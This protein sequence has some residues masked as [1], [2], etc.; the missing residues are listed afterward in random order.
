MDKHL[1]ASRAH[2]Q[3]AVR[4][5]DMSVALTMAYENVPLD[6]EMRRQVME[7][8]LGRWRGNRGEEWQPTP[9]DIDQLM[10]S[11][12]VWL[13]ERV[14]VNWLKG[15]DDAT[16]DQLPPAAWPSAYPGAYPGGGQRSLPSG[17]GGAMPPPLI[18]P[19]P[20]AASSGPYPPGSVSAGMVPAGW[21]PPGWSA[22]SWTPP[23]WVALGPRREAEGASGAEERG[24]AGS[25]GGEPEKGA[26]PADQ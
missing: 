7:D 4:W 6:R 12:T 5:L 19:V 24:E 15:T 10:E 16:P 22:P 8:I 2:L 13:S 17:V 11:T 18:R 9:S 25:D 20:P 26:G 3:A 23:G 14:G 1:P 21:M